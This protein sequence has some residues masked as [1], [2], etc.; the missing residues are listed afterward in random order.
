MGRRYSFEL[1]YPTGAL[2]SGIRAADRYLPTFHRK[3]TGKRVKSAA[4]DAVSLLTALTPNTPVFFSTS[5]LFPADGHVRG[6]RSDWDDRDTE[7]NDDGNSF[8]PVGLIGVEVRTGS[9]YGLISYAAVTSG[10]SDL[11]EQSR[12]IWAQFDAMRLASGGLTALFRGSGPSCPVL[13]DGRE[14]VAL[15]F[16]DYVLEERAEYWHIDVDHYTADV[17]HAAK[18]EPGE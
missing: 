5:L 10:M 2:E 4:P 8:L 15:N 12:A 6:F 9:R 14:R 7:W 17:L 1:F 13:P 11:F 18:G 16:F 3:R